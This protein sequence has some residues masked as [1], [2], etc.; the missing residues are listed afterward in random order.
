MQLCR[1][2]I[3]PTSPYIL[4]FGEVMNI[5]KVQE[6]YSPQTHTTTSIRKFCLLPESKDSLGRPLNSIYAGSSNLP[7]AALLRASWVWL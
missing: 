2:K 1:C 4:A 3:T 6:F 5:G 7:R